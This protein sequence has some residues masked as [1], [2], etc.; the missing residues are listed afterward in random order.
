[1]D[2]PNTIPTPVQ[3]AGR[4]I[5]GANASKLLAAHKSLADGVGEIK[6]ILT[7]SG[8]LT[9]ELPR[10]P[11][12]S[13]EAASLTLSEETQMRLWMTKVDTTISLCYQR[14]ADRDPTENLGSV[15]SAT[16]AALREAIGDLPQPQARGQMQTGLELC[17]HHH[18]HDWE[19]YITPGESNLAEKVDDL[20]FS[21]RLVTTFRYF[22][23]YFYHALRNL[24]SPEETMGR[25][26]DELNSL[27]T[28]AIA[29][30]SPDSPGDTSLSIESE[31]EVE[32]TEPEDTIAIEAAA[33]EYEAIWD[34]TL[35]ARTIDVEAEG[36]DDAVPVEGVLFR[37]DEPSECA[38]SVGPRLPLYISADVAAKALKHV[39]GRPLD[40]HE[41]LEAHGG[42]VVG[43]IVEGAVSGQD[44]VIRGFLH[45]H[46]LPDK[47]AEIRAAARSGELG[48]SMVGS[49]AWHRDKVDGRDVAVVDR[50]RL[51]G[52]TILRASVATYQKTRVMLKSAVDREGRSLLAAVADSEPASEP[53]AASANDTSESPPEDQTHKEDPIETMSEP[54]TT[55]ATVAAPDLTEKLLTAIESLASRLTAI[56]AKQAAEEEAEAER[57]AAE[58]AAA[59]QAAQL[60]AMATKVAEALAPTI[61]ER[62]N[63][64]LATQQRPA[65]P[66]VRRATQAAP[67]VPQSTTAVAAQAIDP[68]MQN[69]LNQLARTPDHNITGR[70][71]LKQQIFD[72]ER[73]SSIAR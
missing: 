33:G 55:T 30:V 7:N 17:W 29:Q 59:Q 68:Q 16:M 31:I 11:F 10:A 44:A 13:V 4:A 60:E 23:W 36:D 46:H 41:S 12:S 48:M 18:G 20:S 15:V 58:Q 27:L 65:A 70:I 72:L 22:T 37:V 38:P 14:L 71:A 5:S 8:W 50:M 26:V 61:D 19:P 6:Q 51:K 52:G 42:G 62:I 1:M 57:L 66:G 69:L 28:A 32:P 24:G 39:M 49:V 53:I 56:E 21:Y 34:L 43:A 45:G 54:T 3:A 2:D 25:L 47:V 9:A 64:V 63:A 67:V 40:A 73:N 35:A